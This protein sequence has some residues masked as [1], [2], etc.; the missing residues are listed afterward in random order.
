[1]FETLDTELPRE[2]NPSGRLSRSYKLSSSLWRPES[3]STTTTYSHLVDSDISSSSFN[4]SYIVQNIYCI[5]DDLRILDSRASSGRKT[6]AAYCS[7]SNQDKVHIADGS[8]PPIVKKDSI[9]CIPS[10][11]LPL[12]NLVLFCISNKTEK[13]DF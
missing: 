3:P 2:I 11:N 8:L 4:T 10:I 5:Y 1:M 9:K 13:P 7:C 12:D 6:F